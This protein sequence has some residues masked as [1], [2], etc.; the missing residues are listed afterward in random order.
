MS[1]LLLFKA[2]VAAGT[3]AISG[4]G[5]LASTGR[6]GGVGAATAAAT[7]TL[8][9]IGVSA[10]MGAGTVSGTGTLTSTGQ[11]SQGTTP[12]PGWVGGAGIPRSWRSPGPRVQP[13]PR[14]P[15]PVPV[16]PPP[17]MASGTGVIA[18]TSTLNGVGYRS[19]SGAGDIDAFASTAA[20]GFGAPHQ[21]HEDELLML[22]LT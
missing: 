5:A 10:R 13:P 7:G 3:G 16:R 15:A 4:T 6:K 12:T 2:K 1:L 18:A 14:P 21:R 9:S 8:T 19:A 22:V 11:S 17:I 20:D